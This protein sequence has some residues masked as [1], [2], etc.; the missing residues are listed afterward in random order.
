MAIY[1]SK[2]HGNTF[3][4]VVRAGDERFDI[5]SRAKQQQWHALG[6]YS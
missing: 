3:L 6:G 4:R 1:P 5:R 2:I